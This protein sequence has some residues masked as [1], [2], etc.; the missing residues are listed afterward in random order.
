MLVLAGVLV[1]A[2]AGVGSLAFF[3]ASADTTASLGAGRIFPGVRTTS[4]FIVGDRSGGGTS[5]DRSSPFALSDDGRTTT[6]G[7]WST[8]FAGDRYLQFDLSAPLPA[9]LPA[10]SVSLALGLAS[11][12]PSGT[13]CVYAQV[14]RISD[15]TPLATYGSAGSPIGCTSGTSQASFTV[16]LPV[17][18]STDDA[19]DLRVRIYGRNSAAAASVLDELTVSGTTPSA[20]FVL[21]PV[22]YTDAATSV[23]NSSPWELQGP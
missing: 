17:V 15:D 1:C 8:A 16:S 20:A 11:A 13:V 23:A 18:A 9:S 21:Y 5:V 2:G 6:T 3:T 12:S 14:R 19:N 4:A 22:R 10:S 7:A